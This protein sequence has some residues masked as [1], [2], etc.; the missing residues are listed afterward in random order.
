MFFIRGIFTMKNCDI[1][2]APQTLQV[3]DN[4]I[5]W[6]DMFRAVMIFAIAWGHSLGVPSMSFGLI[7]RYLYSFHV[8]AF[9]FI[10]GYL[11]NRKSVPFVS[12]VSKKFKTLMIPYYVFSLLSIA[13]FSVLGSFASAGLGVEAKSTGILPNIWGMIY[14]N[15]DT[16]YMKWNLALWFIPCLFCTSL[17]FFGIQFI[18]SKASRKIN[19][20]TF[21]AL[22]LVLSLALA[23]SN[24]YVLGLRVLPFGLETTIYMLPFFIVGY[25]IK[26]SVNFNNIRSSYKFL[27]GIIALISGGAI[28]IF[29]QNGINYI[30]SIYQNIFLFYISSMLT[31][32]GFVLIFQLFSFKWVRFVGKNSLSILLMHKFPILLLQIILGKYIAKSA[33]MGVTVTFFIA[34]ISCGL[35]LLVG[36]MIKRIFP[37][38]LGLKKQKK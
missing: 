28:A 12:F 27:I 14:A 21:N 1:A 4:R 36:E 24:Y 18:F 9:F 33:A 5:H 35:S 10:S 22:V 30:N 3:P 31:V 11:F 23:V 20:H 16:G 29:V 13:A 8:P 25:W 6:I 17:L 15:G 38:M 34:V 7:I 37:F 2:T 32:I 26:G 19:F